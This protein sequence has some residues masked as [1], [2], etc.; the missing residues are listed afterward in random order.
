MSEKVLICTIAAVLIIG[1][2]YYKFSN[3]KVKIDANKITEVTYVYETE[4]NKMAMFDVTN[5]INK[6]DISTIVKSLNN[7]E[8]IPARKEEGTYTL[9]HIELLVLGDRWFSIYKQKDGTFT[10]M[11]QIDKESNAENSRKQTTIHSEALLNYFIKFKEL[12]KRL[13]PNITW[14]IK[15]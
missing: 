5:S 8:L 11:Y 15:K 12:S 9:E 4:K 6:N 1:S 14:D 3:R 13:T 10:A 7:G 2:I